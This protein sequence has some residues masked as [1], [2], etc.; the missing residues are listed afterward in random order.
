MPVKIT[1]SCIPPAVYEVL[2]EYESEDPETVNL[3]TL[4]ESTNI[5]SSGQFASADA[6]GLKVMPSFRYIKAVGNSMAE[7]VRCCGT[8]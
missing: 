8:G 4:D 5:T 2:C 1:K 7:E 3:P 6:P